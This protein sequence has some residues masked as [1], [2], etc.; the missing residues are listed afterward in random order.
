[1]HERG[2]A[3]RDSGTRRETE[4]AG[5]RA[6]GVEDVQRARAVARTQQ[7]GDGEERALF[8]KDDVVLAAV[9]ERVQLVEALVGQVVQEQR[10]PVARDAGAARRVLLAGEE[11]A[12][13]GGRPGGESAP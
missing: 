5:E 12:A 3:Q 1:M 9:Q 10:A 4:P 13:R 11:G 7:P 8:R 6:D 2:V